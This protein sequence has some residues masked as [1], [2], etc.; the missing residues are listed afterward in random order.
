MSNSV[1]KPITAKNEEALKTA[2]NEL[3]ADHGALTATQQ[4]ALI[5]S[6]F[7]TEAVKK[8]YFKKYYYDDQDLNKYIFLYD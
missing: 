1:F 5:R 8:R 3:I 2:I 6:K 4:R 7:I